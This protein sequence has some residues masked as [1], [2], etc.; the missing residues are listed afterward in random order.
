M[1]AAVY[2]RQNANAAEKGA[3]LLTITGFGDGLFQKS[4]YTAVSIEI[5][6]NESLG[7]LPTD[8]K[9]FGQTEGAHSINDTEINGLRLS[10]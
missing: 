4:F 9:L 8:F 3:R 5:L 10:S 6:I 1:V 7:H 2:I